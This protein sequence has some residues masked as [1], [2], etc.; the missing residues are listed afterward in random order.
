MSITTDARAALAT[1]SGRTVAGMD[2]PTVML[3][4]GGAESG[5]NDQEQGDKD[6]DIQYGTCQG[7]TSWGWLQVHNVHARALTAAAGSSDPCA[8]AKWLYDPDNCAAFANQLIPAGQAL[9]A[10]QLGR[11]WTTWWS[12]DGGQ[13]SAGY[14]QGAYRLYLPQAIAAIA[15]MTIPPL[16]RA[17]AAPSRPLAPAVLPPAAAQATG[18]P[19][20]VVPAGLALIGLSVLGAGLRR[21]GA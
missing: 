6:I 3:A 12:T 14:G 17:A 8:W 2:L 18:L 11:T 10:A 1:W 7:Y 13:T 16:P 5:W 9:T 19:A 15:A 20:W 21:V 4:I